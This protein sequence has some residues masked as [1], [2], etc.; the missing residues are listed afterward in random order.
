MPGPTTRSK[1]ASASTASASARRTKT[2]A[3][4]SSRKAT[5][6]QKGAASASSK[7]KASSKTRASAASKKKTSTKVRPSAAANTASKKGKR[8]G[9]VAGA[10]ASTKRRTK[11]D[12]EGVDAVAVKRS[13]ATKTQGAE[14]TVI[15]PFKPKTL[16]MKRIRRKNDTGF[17]VFC[18]EMR[19]KKD[20]EVAALDFPRQSKKCGEL[21]RLVPQEQK[22]IYNRQ[23]EADNKQAAL[24]VLDR[25][26]R[27]STV[28]NN[29]SAFQ[30][31]MRPVVKQEM[32]GSTLKEQNKR[33]KDMWD[34]LPLEDKAKY[35][36]IV[37]R[38]QALNRIAHLQWQRLQNAPLPTA[39]EV[40]AVIA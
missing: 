24:L 11:N 2:S 31:E 40:D 1:K 15:P 16:I 6:S 21:W 8:Q 19:S 9:G 29:F 14:A 34:Q 5:A 26:K 25:P 17:Q 20:S 32:P 28:Q 12:A 38:E 27:P 33:I 22:E 13:R 7:K 4:T 3:P 10:S 30:K 23:A 18:R 36:A 35:R 39:A 37:N